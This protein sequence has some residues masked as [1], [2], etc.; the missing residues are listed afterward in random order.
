MNLYLIS[1]KANDDFNTF[2]S[3]VVCCENAE[4]ARD[5]H[6]ADS[7]VDWGSEF[8]RGSASWASNREDVTVQLL[9]VADPSIREGVV[10]AS[11]NAG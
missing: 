8:V 5:L 1:Q 3:A 10:C 4:I 11:F 7:I 2:D 9:G 6:P